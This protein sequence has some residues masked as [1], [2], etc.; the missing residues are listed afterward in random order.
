[1]TGTPAAHDPFR[2]DVVDN[3]TIEWD[4]QSRSAMASY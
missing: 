2:I 1:M 4:A 3:M